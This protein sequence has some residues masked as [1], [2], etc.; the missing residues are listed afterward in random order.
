MSFFRSEVLSLLY[1]GELGVSFI[2]DYCSEGRG[3][4]S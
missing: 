1:L 3:F 4:T 2:Q